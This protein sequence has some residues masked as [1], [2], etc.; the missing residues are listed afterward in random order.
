M[1]ST[2]I[3]PDSGYC[4]VWFIDLRPTNSI[5]LLF[6]IPINNKANDSTARNDIVRGHLVNM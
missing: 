6:G 1:K 5:F 4:K 3:C 2:D